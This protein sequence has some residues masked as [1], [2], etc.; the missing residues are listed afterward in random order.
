MSAAC[1]TKR[2]GASVSPSTHWLPTCLDK[3]DPSEQGSEWGTEWGSVSQIQEIGRAVSSVG[4]HL[5]NLNHLSSPHTA[6]RDMMLPFGISQACDNE[7]R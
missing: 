6:L 4:A 3:S 5:I 7:L 2:D 1:A